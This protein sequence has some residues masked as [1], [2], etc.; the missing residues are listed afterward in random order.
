MDQ[1]TIQVSKKNRDRFKKL[2]AKHAKELKLNKLFVDDFFAI[3]LDSYEK[4]NG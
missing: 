1:T 2:Q 4:T 3:V